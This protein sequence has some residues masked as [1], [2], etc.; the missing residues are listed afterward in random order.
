MESFKLKNLKSVIP[1]QFLGYIYCFDI[2]NGLVK[3]GHTSNIETR[4]KSHIRTYKGLIDENTIIHLSKPHTN[5]EETEAEIF[6]MLKGYRE[7][8]KEHFRLGISEV[9]N[10]FNSLNMDFDIEKAKAKRE[11]EKKEND[12]QGEKLFEAYKK[13]DHSKSSLLMKELYRKILEG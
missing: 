1:H 4:M 9:V 13:M 10:A 2:S 11:K 3:I 12:I 6:E 8:E 7:T 5:H